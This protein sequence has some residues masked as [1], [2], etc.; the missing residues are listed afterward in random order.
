MKRTIV[1][2]FSIQSFTAYTLDL[3]LKK[4]PLKRDKSTMFHNEKKMSSY[5]QCAVNRTKRKK[6]LILQIQPKS[7]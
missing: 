3:N 7:I 4:K 5:N 6:E 2:S 1:R